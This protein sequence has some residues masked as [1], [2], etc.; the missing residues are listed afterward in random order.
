MSAN[1]DALSLDLIDSMASIDEF[2]DFANIKP[3][4]PLL[5]KIIETASATAKRL[6]IALDKNPARIEKLPDAEPRLDIDAINRF[7]N[8]G[9]CPVCNG[10]RE[11]TFPFGNPPEI[12]FDKIYFDETE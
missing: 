5:L 3:H 10:K 7:L 1:A 8:G 6:A 11:E 2:A 4:L 9:F 12:D